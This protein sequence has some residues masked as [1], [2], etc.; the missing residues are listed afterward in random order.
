MQRNVLVSLILLILSI[1]GCGGGGGGST[2]TVVVSGMASKGPFVSGIVN[3]Y[4][5]SGGIEARTL[6]ESG[7]INSDGQYGITISASTAPI[8]IEV[9]AGSVY[10]DEA[11]AGTPADKRTTLGTPL[12]A[13]LPNAAANHSVTVTPFTELAVRKAALAGSLSQAAIDEANALIRQLYNLPNILTT[14]PI[15]ASAEITSNDSAAVDYGL[16]LAAISQLTQGSDLSTAL[17]ILEVDGNML[18]SESADSFKNALDTFLRSGN[19][20]NQ[21]Q[22]PNLAATSFEDVGTTVATTAVIEVGL[23]ESYSNVY[24]LNFRM[25][26]SPE[27]GVTGPPAVV[28]INEA[29]GVAGERINPLA[30]VLNGVATIFL[31][32][33]LTSS[34]G[35]TIIANRP[36]I[37]LIY[38]LTGGTL[39]EFQLN[40]DPQNNSPIVPLELT[41]PADPARSITQAL[42]P[43][44]Y[45]VAVTY[46]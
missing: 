29:A 46:Q 17:E 25:G 19:N 32:K 31:T 20:I 28:V 27:A 4:D 34:P 37:R 45:Y 23:R 44:D 2:S 40:L 38:T 21:T 18:T 33:N 43:A 5:V 10:I 42:T 3:V 15:D 6:L 13:I 14:L 12:R 24:S 7:A 36:V 22:F 8:L 11:K 39:P 35:Y 1:S 41:D 16:A 30:G 9:A 26:V